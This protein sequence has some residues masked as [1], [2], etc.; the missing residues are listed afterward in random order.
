[1]RRPRAV[2]A[3]R[4]VW[5]NHLRIEMNRR[6]QSTLEYAVLI[7]VVVAALIA[8]QIYMKRGV[9][10]KLRSATDD[11]GAQYVPGKTKSDYSVSSDSTRH[12]VLENSGVTTSTLKTDEVQSRS[13][14]ETVT[15]SGET[16]L[17]SK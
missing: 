16:Q 6:G 2:A 11:I 8:M 17:F 3:R 7:A 14:H 13:G 10:D 9:Q 12:E 4:S 5:S 15:T 1:M